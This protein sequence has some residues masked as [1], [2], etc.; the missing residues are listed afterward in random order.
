MSAEP[1]K[2][3]KEGAIKVLHSLC[4][5]I[6]KTQQWPQ[7][8]KHQSSSQFPR[9]VIPKNVLTIAQLH[10][11]R[12]LIRSCLKSFMPAFSIMWTNNFQMLK[13]GL[14]KEE[15]LEIKL[16]TFAG[17]E[18]KQGNF[19]KISI[20]VSSTMLKPLTVWI[21]TNCGKLLERW[22]YQTILPVSWETCIWVKNNS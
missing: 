2:S 15:K 20:S 6:W 16:Q 3:L 18:R 17:L 21:V 7:T 19:R 22:E 5:Q 8:G 11:S 1:A 10:S 13:L 12:V 4:Q 14:E 9:R